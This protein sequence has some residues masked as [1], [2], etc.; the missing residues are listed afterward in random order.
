MLKRKIIRA[1]IV[2]TEKLVVTVLRMVPVYIIVG[3]GAVGTFIA[4][5]LRIVTIC[6]IGINSGPE[7]MT[8]FHNYY[9]ELFLIAWIIIYVA[10]LLLLGRRI[11]PRLPFR[12]KP[13]ETG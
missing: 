11:R 8:L 6:I 12:A 9:G 4:N 2:G 3:I 5:I 1:T 10:I 13:S 7:A